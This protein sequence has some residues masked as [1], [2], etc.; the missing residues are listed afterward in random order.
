M[1]TWRYGISLRGRG[2]CTCSISPASPI[3]VVDRPR[4]WDLRKFGP[5]SSEDWRV[6]LGY[7]E[8]GD[9]FNP[10]V[11]FLRRRGI[12]NLDLG[13]GYTFRPDSFLNLQQ[14]RPHMSFARFWDFTGFVKTSFL[15]FDY[16]WRFNDSSTAKT[17]I[18][19]TEE[20]VTVPFEISDGIFVPPGRY[21]HTETEWSYRSNRGAPV[22]F[23][24]QS[25]I[26]GFFGGDRVRLSPSISMRS[27][28]TFNASLSWSRNDISLPGGSFVANLSSAQVAYNFSPRIFLQALVQYNDSD[29]LWS[30][31]LRFGLLRQANTGLFVVYNDT[32][33]L[34]DI[35]P[36]GSG[37]T[38]II[39]FSQMFDLID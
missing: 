26:G 4:S 39:K 38:L 21:E 27:G 18:N 29:D 32:R 8:I 15:H 24:L 17:T 19:F 31:N 12:R 16:D 7:V 20:G 37:R 1:R 22:S 33:G 23:G 36:L 14:M 2:K 3:T 25:T 35:T 6:T 30:A 34:N 28:E 5:T 9:N 10:E 11:G 13:I